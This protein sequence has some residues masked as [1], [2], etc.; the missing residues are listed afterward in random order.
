MDEKTIIERNKS[1]IFTIRGQDVL[2]DADLASIYGIE[3]RRVNEQVKRNID[4]FPED[5][6]FQLTNQEFDHL[7]SQN[8][9]SKMHVALR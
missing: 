8:A 7:K 3:T 6:R 4:K 9:T 1:A 5:F 2:L